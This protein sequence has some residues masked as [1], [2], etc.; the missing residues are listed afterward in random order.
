[1]D[2]VHPISA[3]LP[4]EHH[5]SL[6]PGPTICFR[7]AWAGGHGET[8]SAW[9]LVIDPKNDT[10]ALGSPMAK[11]KT[12]NESGENNKIFRTILSVQV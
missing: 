3:S 2:T 5:S 8:F 12:K 4:C 7:E 1:M 11:D 9:Q 10:D 6:L